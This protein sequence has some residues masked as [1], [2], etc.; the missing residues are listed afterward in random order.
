MI[1]IVNI[2][3]LSSTVALQMS[4]FLL[5]GLSP[6]FSHD[7][8]SLSTAALHLMRLIGSLDKRILRFTS[9]YFLAGQL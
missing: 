9:V 2:S 6:V 7:T 1:T 8:L 4:Q 3:I 5:F